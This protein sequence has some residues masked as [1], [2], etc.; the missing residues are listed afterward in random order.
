[1][2]QILSVERRHNYM[3]T[4]I[5]LINVYIDASLVPRPSQTNEKTWV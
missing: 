1:M 3:Y 2:L 5:V 4:Y